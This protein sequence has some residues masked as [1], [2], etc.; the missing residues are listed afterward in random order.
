MKVPKEISGT[1]DPAV[2]D[3]VSQVTAP[4]QEPTFV[5]SEDSGVPKGWSEYV[6]DVDPLEAGKGYTPRLFR[7]TEAEGGVEPFRQMLI[8]MPDEEALDLAVT[9]DRGHLDWA[10]RT[11][12]GIKPEVAAKVQ[13]V[14]QIQGIPK[15]MVFKNQEEASDWQEAF[16]VIK[17]LTEKDEEGEYK[18]PKTLAFMTDPDNAVLAKDD[19]AL[20]ARVED[21]AH[22]FSA[23]PQRYVW[24]KFKEGGKSFVRGLA[25]TGAI[26]LRAVQLGLGMPGPVSLFVR[27]DREQAF[28]PRD[29]QFY[30]NA[31]TLVEKGSD[32]TFATAANLLDGLSKAEILEPDMLAERK[33]FTKYLGSVAETVPQFAGVLA[34]TY[35]TGSPTAGASVMGGYIFG[36]TYEQL[37]L[38]GVPEDLAI[39]AATANALVQSALEFVALGKWVKWFKTAP[40]SRR[41]AQELLGVLVTEYGTEF[42]QQFP[43]DMTRIYAEESAK[44]GSVSDIVD[45]VF[46]NLPSTI[47][48]GLYEGAVVLPLSLIGAAASSPRAIRHQQHLKSN[49]AFLTDLG[50]AVELNKLHKLSPDKHT[51]FVQTVLEQNGIEDIAYIS[52]E[53]FKEFQ[54]AAPEV[55]RE[56]VA[57][58]SLQDQLVEAEA[59]GGDI[60]LSISELSTKLAGTDAGALLTP[61]LRLEADGLTLHEQ[62]ELVERAR[63]EAKRVQEEFADLLATN[64]LP[65]QLMNLREQLVTP[66]DEGGAGLTPGQA[67]AHLGVLWARA[68]K[69]AAEMGTTPKEWIDSLKLRL[70]VDQDGVKVQGRQRAERAK[71]PSQMEMDER[72]DFYDTIATQQKGVPEAAM[73]KVQNLMAGVLFKPIEHTGDLIHRMTED[74]KFN[75]TAGYNIVLDKVEK[76]LG[77]LTQPYGFMKE[78]E[79]NIKNNAEVRGVT[80]EAYRAELMAALAEYAEAHRNMPAFNEVQRLARDAAVA[81][82]ELDIDRAV[83][84]LTKLKDYL[85]EGAEAWAARATEADSVQT[86]KDIIEVFQSGVDY[87]ENGDIT[88]NEK[89]ERWFGTSVVVDEDGNP[90]KVFHGTMRDFSVFK[91][92]ASGPETNLGPGF[93]FTNKEEDA[94][95][96]YAHISGG[97]VQAKLRGRA[98][99]LINE[100]INLNDW[101]EAMRRAKEELDYQE[102]G[103]LLEVYLKLEN[104]VIIGGDN[105]TFFDYTYQL[106]NDPEFQEYYDKAYDELLEDEGG[107]KTNVLDDEVMALA[108]ERFAADH[109]TEP[110]GILLDLVEKAREI[111]MDYMAYDL[112]G[113]GEFLMHAF[114]QDG[115]KAG[116][117][118]KLLAAELRMA[119]VTIPGTPYTAAYEIIN[120]ALKELGFDGYIDYTVS[121]KFPFMALD[122]DTAHYIV[123]DPKQVKSTKSINFDTENANIYEQIYYQGGEIVKRAPRYG[124]FFSGLH[125]AALD[126][127]QAKGTPKQML[128]ALRKSKSY[129]GEEYKAIPALKSLI[130]DTP[131]N[132]T[133]TRDQII[134][135]VAESFVEL[136]FRTHSDIT[137]GSSGPDMGDIEYYPNTSW[138]AAPE[139]TVDI[140]NQYSTVEFPDSEGN[141][142][143]FDISYH[144]DNTD[145]EERGGPDIPNQKAVYLDGRRL[146]Q[147]N[148]G[149]SM[150][151]HQAEA[152]L[153][154]EL[155]VRLGRKLT[156]AEVVRLMPTKARPGWVE[157][158]MPLR[159]KEY[160]IDSESEG[161]VKIVVYDD[162]DYPLRPRGAYTNT[163]SQLR[164]FGPDP[165]YDYLLG[166]DLNFRVMLRNEETGEETEYSSFE[167]AAD[168]IEG[169]IF[170]DYYD[171]D[172]EAGIDRMYQER[173]SNGE[174]VKYMEYTIGAEHGSG[175]TRLNANYDEYLLTI[176]D[177]WLAEPWIF[178]G[179][180]DQIPNVIGFT[181]VSDKTA[182]IGG[183]EHH[184]Q[185]LEELQSDLH[186]KGRDFGYFTAE[187][188]VHRDNNRSQAYLG[189]LNVKKELDKEYQDDGRGDP[190][191]LPDF[192]SELY[193]SD[194]NLK[195]QIL[196]FLTAIEGLP[197]A[198]Q[199]RF[200]LANYM[201][202]R[203][204]APESPFKDAWSL[205][206]FKQMVLKA[207]DGGYEAI[208]WSNGNIHGER[209]DKLKGVNRIVAVTRP[210]GSVHVEGYDVAYDNSGQTAL[211]S[212][213]KAEFT[214]RSEKSL[215]TYLGKDIAERVLNAN[216]F[217]TT[218]GVERTLDGRGLRMGGEG[219]RIFYDT[220]LPAQVRKWLKSMK[221]DAVLEQAPLKGFESLGDQWVVKLTPDLQAK[222]THDGLT[223]Y[224]AAEE[225]NRKR[226]RGRVQ[227]TPTETIITLFESAD[228]TTFVHE[229]AHIF[230]EDMKR[231]VADGTASDREAKDLVAIRQ[232]TGDSELGTEAHEFIAKAFEGYLIEGKAPATKLVESFRNY[233]TWML[234]LYRQIGGME[235]V[236]MNDTLRGIFDSMLASEAEMKEVR[237]YYAANE[238]LV[239]SMPG[240]ARQKAHL[241]RLH[242]A[243]RERALQDHVRRALKTFLATDGMRERIQSLAASQV[244]S[245]PV[246]RAVQIAIDRG[247]LN[248]D[249]IKAEYGEDAYNA[250]KALHPRL[251]T[252]NGTL[253]LTELALELEYDSE[254]A[255]IADIAKSPK[256]A[257]AIETRV[258]ELIDERREQIRE[259]LARDEFL[260][261]EEAYHND[262]QRKYLL[263]EARLVAKHIAEQTGRSRRRY[264]EKAYRD[265]ARA[266]LETKTVAEA[267]RYDLYS[268]AEAKYGRQFEAAVIKEDWEAAQEA[269]E[270]Q[271]INH[272]LVTEAVRV[273]RLHEQA[274]RQAKTLAK[275]KSILDR[276]RQVIRHLLFK[277][278][279]AGTDAPHVTEEAFASTLGEIEAGPAGVPLPN[280]VKNFQQQQDY[281]TMPVTD[282]FDLMQGI[283]VIGAR[284]RNAVK[285]QKNEAAR[286]IDEVA[287]EAARPMLNR[288]K[289]DPLT[290]HSRMHKLRSFLRNLGA[291]TMHMLFDL[292]RAD[293]YTN[294]G[295]DGEMG[296]NEKLHQAIF[297]RQKD[298]IKALDAFE[299]KYLVDINDRL[300]LLAR[301]FRER[302]GNRPFQIPGA[303]LPGVLRA[304]GYKGW[305]GEMVLS[306]VLNMGSETGIKTL[307]NGFD[308]DL[309][310]LR[311][312]AA[313]LTSHELQLVQDIWN[314]IET[315]WPDMEAAYFSLNGVHLDRIAAEPIRLATA[316]GKTVTLRGGYYPL[317]YDP[318]ASRKVAEFTEADILKNEAAAVHHM[319][320]PRDSFTKKRTGSSNPILLNISPLY[321]HIRDTIRYTHLS[322]ILT[323]ISKVFKHSDWADAY[324]D[325]MGAERYET[326]IPWLSQIARPE[327]TV[328][329]NLDQVL[330]TF[331]KLAIIKALGARL[332]TGVK[333]AFSLTST[334]SKLGIL[335][336]MKGVARM[337]THPYQSVTTVEAMSPFM[338]DR[339]H[340]IEVEMARLYEQVSPFKRSV[341]VGGRE[342]TLRDLQ[343]M[344]LVNIRLGDI[345]GAYPTWLAAFHQ[346]LDATGDAD[347]AISYADNIVAETQPVSSAMFKNLWQTGGKRNT[348]LGRLIRWTISPFVG[349]TMK[350]GS[351]MRTHFNAWTEGKMST[352]DY[353]RHVV[354][355]N[356]LPP[357]MVALLVPSGDDEEELTWTDLLY[358][359][360]SYWTSWMPGANTVPRG[361]KYGTFGGVKMT[362]PWLQQIDNAIV[363]P[364]KELSEGDYLEALKA[365]AAATEF[366]LGIPALTVAKEID[367]TVKKIVGDEED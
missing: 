106:E 345:M 214:A 161:E 349:W 227:F 299:K 71:H 367:D 65:S 314:A 116:I 107:D 233:R 197:S 21:L 196:D 242:V 295:P 160:T 156:D 289:V 81:L 34:A 43:E 225:N 70:V 12:R 329:D 120:R 82:G 358:Y 66:K 275:S 231:R 216:A 262:A 77:S 279:L 181:R 313:M 76:I 51:A 328:A 9:A 126:I 80:E 346:K 324:T 36:T 339:A 335:P 99:E 205:I 139:H 91:P 144:T 60:T 204:G 22:S 265:S 270:K 252:N 255:L 342:V 273:R 309:T 282:F 171:R 53:D 334:I 130:E 11:V 46:D 61:R 302:F 250:M 85:D 355:E 307:Q 52:S 322:E 58:L 59:T 276:H 32:V 167:T 29:V 48:D 13:Q 26:S 127:P 108:A 143:S 226:P 57:S 212:T 235:D 210:D 102:D 271:L 165:E 234:N 23:S 224:Q 173:L 98:E 147:P 56:V 159:E 288:R 215:A 83:Q 303:P 149:Y 49:L 352:R 31:R 177:T 325:L 366:Q 101:D 326:L 104:P 357:L 164:L 208:A 285:L 96:N 283:K 331:Q 157:E 97:D 63:A 341:K 182:V 361:L 124:G 166:T 347:A 42:L 75:K 109:G 319:N 128:A 194:A 115:M 3:T 337:I 119:D 348:A 88:R 86:V 27:Q 195:K 190:S 189:F 1:P 301:R 308:M 300:G 24:E 55:A 320:K 284:G 291:E 78:F 192:A 323:D 84:D 312:V 217:N 202:L 95:A 152:L 150:L 278:G 228:V 35:F 146:F 280:A 232:L 154:Q 315:L 7:D 10:L 122:A 44:G 356:L 362:Q 213:K 121:D 364:I 114:P 243:A 8:E 268:R 229:L 296:P 168:A 237:F 5:Q 148:R 73:L 41:L 123:F 363:T 199:A 179:H 222:I 211:Q 350:Y 359:G 318:K 79:E 117:A 353:A 2:E 74:L 219:F 64:R 340:K 89:L 162:Y 193:I 118:L 254:E 16:E 321:R 169:D 305:T 241:Q 188:A 19:A 304:A 136:E 218:R 186:Q 344:A 333:Q 286:V 311:A 25:K 163:D 230:L 172:M 201:R 18:Y 183:Q 93:Y 38:Q 244:D 134:D 277:A 247:S 105:P 297:D 209:W 90:L 133:I 332:K 131:E 220:V 245:M 30:L 336:T 327:P 257:T 248:A 174:D 15:D 293:G 354:Y 103:V 92:E 203:K 294:L 221:T 39:R 141:L 256:R 113:V 100:D 281:R 54:Q 28:Q 365:L 137:G 62:A 360:T 72:L 223:L 125:Q 263:S 207:L 20:L 129:S 185:F 206:L 135:L 292:K 240:D 316:D 45:R 274:I 87:D 132:E 180:W 40:G 68:S 37:T 112:S 261:G 264:E 4:V 67:D 178:S 259:T 258:D 33:G 251:V 17:T 14:A 176:D 239:G 249:R 138:D 158:V 111:A 69:V 94:Y 343:H 290:N 260:P 351:R 238:S 200:A 310:E 155:E 145:Y 236:R 272:F 170:M 246:Y 50:K 151:A 6:A 191:S 110:S 184:T 142:Q 317:R 269:K 330:S 267:I 140:V 175:P 187:E 153:R 47:K 253:D 266:I 298:A 198:D 287:T 338:R 306:F